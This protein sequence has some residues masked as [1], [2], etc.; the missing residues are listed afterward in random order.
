MRRSVIDLDRDLPARERPLTADALSSVFGGC[1]D[2]C[3]WIMTLGIQ[4]LCCPGK[5][6]TAVQGLGYQCRPS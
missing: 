2:L 6:C 1:N 4:D 3:Y 5:R